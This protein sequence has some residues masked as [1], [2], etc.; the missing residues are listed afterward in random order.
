VEYAPGGRPFQP[1]P[2]CCVRDL[3]G[4]DPEAPILTI[5]NLT[6]RLDCVAPTP[7]GRWVVVHGSNDPDG[8]V[9]EV[10]VYEIATA[11]QA[12]SSS[13]APT[14]DVGH[15]PIDPTGAFLAF[16]PSDERKAW[17]D[18]ATGRPTW[19]PPQF[20]A[21]LGPGAALWCEKAEDGRSFLLHRAG[22][23]AP[24]VALGIDAVRPNGQ[25]VFSRQGD[26][27]VWGDADG[28]VTV[29]NLQ[30]VQSRLNEVGLGW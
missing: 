29:C 7:D 23:D 26:L 17:V 4:P 28:S 16:R 12:W 8:K 24:L 3:L 2:V 20:P 5:R 30:E 15:L 25:P 27:L 6:R 22:A 18:I 19:T 13:S 10:K 9:G 21:A 1:P 11:R 14:E